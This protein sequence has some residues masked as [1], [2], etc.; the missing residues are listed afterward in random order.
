MSPRMRTENIRRAQSW[1][2]RASGEDEQ[3]GNDGR[4]TSRGYFDDF[5]SFRSSEE[6][7]RGAP[8]LGAEFA[9]LK[10]VQG[11]TITS[12]SHRSCT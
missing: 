2:R 9:L 1:R 10:A 5:Q 3:G 11:E 12:Q 4:E 6:G 7:P 8:Y